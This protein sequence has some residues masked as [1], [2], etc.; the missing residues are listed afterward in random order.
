[1][2]KPI[3]VMMQ[4][5]TAFNESFKDGVDEGGGKAVSMCVHVRGKCAA[6]STKEVH[7]NNANST[8]TPTT[9]TST[10]HTNTPRGRS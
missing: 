4:V 3:L 8:N 10:T 5:P 2:Y 1:M 6:V 7:Y 9:S